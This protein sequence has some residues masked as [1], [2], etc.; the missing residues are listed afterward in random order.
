MNRL[1]SLGKKL[2][3]KIKRTKFLNLENTINLKVM[4]PFKRKKN[5]K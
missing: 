1:I 2:R 5:E 3:K 4:K